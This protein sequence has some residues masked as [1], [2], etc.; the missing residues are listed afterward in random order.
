[1]ESGPGT[2]PV[3]MPVETLLWAEAA[4]GA[5]VEADSAVGAVQ[6]LKPSELSSSGQINKERI[7]D[8]KRKV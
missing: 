6:L 7:N 3:A 2:P 4:T 5:V 8:R 1:M